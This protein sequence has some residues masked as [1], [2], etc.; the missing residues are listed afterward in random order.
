MD[1][2]AFLTYLVGFNSNRSVSDLIFRL[3]MH[4]QGFL[5]PISVSSDAAYISLN[6][7]LFT[8]KFSPNHYDEYV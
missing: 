8:N 7:N 4:V 5:P 1:C 3:E 6:C 2:G